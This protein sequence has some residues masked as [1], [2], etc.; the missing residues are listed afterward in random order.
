MTPPREGVSHSI[1]GLLAGFML[2]NVEHGPTEAFQVVLGLGIAPNVG[3]NFRL[4]PFA[5][6]LRLGP[7]LGTTVPEATMNHDR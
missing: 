2:P 4:P 5:V 1:S 6:C 7:V 3:R